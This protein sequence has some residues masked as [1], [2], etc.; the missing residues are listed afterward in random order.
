MADEEKKTTEKTS[1]D[2]A[3]RKVETAKS[4]G[5]TQKGNT[6]KDISLAEGDSTGNSGNTGNTNAEATKSS[7]YQ[8]LVLIG[9]GLIIIGIIFVVIALYQP[10]VSTE[11]SVSFSIINSED[12][13]TTVAN[14]EVVVSED[15]GDYQAHDESEEQ[16]YTTVAT[17]TTAAATTAAAT[18]GSAS[19]VTY[20]LNLNTCTMEELETLSGI[21][22]ARA[23]AIISYREQIG[24]YTN[25][26]QIKEISGI[27][28]TIFNN[29]KDY[30]T[31]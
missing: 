9:I 12:A 4:D 3:E 7:P 19:S 24:G 31:V 14:N 23:S 10:S 28:D 18:Q 5:A 8:T 16:E 27:G 2:D 25:I 26:E 30:I 20:P 11:S 13:Y 6:A 21:G 22:E 17:A 29:I 15:T 1:A